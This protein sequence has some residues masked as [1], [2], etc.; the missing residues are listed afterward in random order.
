M[1][2]N[3]KHLRN[4]D[5]LWFKLSN[6]KTKGSQWKDHSKMTLNDNVSCRSVPTTTN[7]KY[8]FCKLYHSKIMH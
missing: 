8:D 5:A 3:R 4:N 6:I 7:K 2:Y 1:S